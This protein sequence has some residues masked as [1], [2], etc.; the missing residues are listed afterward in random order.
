M[1]FYDKIFIPIR[2]DSE[3]VEN[4]E[5][6]QVDKFNLNNKRK[7]MFQRNFHNI[8]LKIIIDTGIVN[9]HIIFYSTIQNSNM[10]E[11]LLSVMVIVLSIIDIVDNLL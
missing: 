2:S 4:Y 9:I 7:L 1:G 10:N 3:K 11:K 6:K 5:I 8:K